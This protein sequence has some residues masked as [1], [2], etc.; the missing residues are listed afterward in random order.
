MILQ[1]SSEDFIAS[2]VQPAFSEQTRKAGSR[3]VAIEK[4]SR[5]IV[6]PLIS[7]MIF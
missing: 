5:Y 4:Q 6:A 1:G 3:F 7:L 2:A